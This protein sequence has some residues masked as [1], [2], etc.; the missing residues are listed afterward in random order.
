M[1][2][3]NTYTL[4]RHK[5]GGN[6]VLMIIS[7]IAACLL[8]G[9]SSYAFATGYFG[10]RNSDTPENE[11]SPAHENDA[12]GNNVPENNDIAPD[13]GLQAAT[14]EY[15][16]D[17]EA[18]GTAFV[19]YG[20]NPMEL[21]SF[22]SFI[23]TPEYLAAV[24][25]QDV[26]KSNDPDDRGTL[27][28]EETALSHLYD[29]YTPFRVDKINEIAEM[30]GLSLVGEMFT[31][32][33]MGLTDAEYNEEFYA[34]ATTGPVFA[35]ELY[36]IPSYRHD[37]SIFKFELEYDSTDFTLFSSAKGVLNPLLVFFWDHELA[38]WFPGNTPDEY[39]AWEY[40]NAHGTTLILMR[41]HDNS[42]ILLQTDTSFI[43]A[44]IAWGIYEEPFTPEELEAFADLIDF[45]H[46]K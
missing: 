34:L 42:H 43:S 17:N 7:V 32:F 24:K 2:T 25:W 30:Y 4:R 21:E 35:D 29:A 23:N 20:V 41:S 37:S 18:P 36:P 45:R 3:H 13:D 38:E 27:S 16:G 46:F 8:M 33:S 22:R 11:N 39:G 6:N 19:P 12:S 26:L 9:I 31:S 14:D 1:K 40:V 28:D 44:T 5:R 10:F 15:T